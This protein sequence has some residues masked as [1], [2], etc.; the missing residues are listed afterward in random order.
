MIV[1]NVKGSSRFSKPSTV[2]HSWLEYWEDNKQSLNDDIRYKCP[3]CDE[4][5]TKDHFVGAHVQKVN[6]IDKTWYIIPLCNSCN[7]KKEH[8]NIPQK[9]LLPVPSHLDNE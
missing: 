5:I 8:F 4:Y 7:N 3:V 1:K 2:H 6:D 9:F